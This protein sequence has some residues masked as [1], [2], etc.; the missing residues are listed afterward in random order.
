MLNF[1]VQIRRRVCY[2]ATAGSKAQYCH[3]DRYA[4]GFHPYLA[5]SRLIICPVPAA[6]VLIFG[7]QS[8]SISLSNHRIPLKSNISK[9]LLRVWI[10]C[11]WKPTTSLTTSRPRV[12]DL[13]SRTRLV[14]LAPKAPQLPDF[15]DVPVYD[16]S[17]NLKVRL[18]YNY[19]L[20]QDTDLD[21][22]LA[23]Y[24]FR[25]SS[26]VDNTT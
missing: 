18:L 9:D 15:H 6:A 4:K 11:G 19:R 22:L 16:G 8:V 5:T 14:A 10:S 23:A 1:L 2:Y 12:H 20:H 25:T 7:T 24:T 13:N 3:C 26:D 17:S 21:S